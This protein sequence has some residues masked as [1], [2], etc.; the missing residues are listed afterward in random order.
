MQDLLPMHTE[1]NKHAM[2]LGSSRRLEP[3]GN[4]KTFV[5]HTTSRVIG[6]RLTFIPTTVELLI[7][8]MSE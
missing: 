4:N 7:I 2:A 8:Q 5:C 3:V 6:K 1:V